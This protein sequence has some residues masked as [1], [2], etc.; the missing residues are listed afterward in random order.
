[1]TSAYGQ[2]RCRNR[3][4]PFK[5]AGEILQM[6][7]NSDNVFE[8]WGTAQ[9]KFMKLA[10]HVI[11]TGSEFEYPGC[12]MENVL[13][14]NYSPEDGNIVIVG[15]R[16]GFCSF[17][18]DDMGYRESCVFRIPGEYFFSPKK[19]QKILVGYA[20]HLQKQDKLRQQEQERREYEEYMRLKAKYE[21]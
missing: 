9:Q 18:D 5:Q 6:T 1:M 12:L 2:A 13:G 7:S 14:L 10:E 8:N 4:S 11:Q 16:T 17:D 19:W 3:S 21:A 15:D 20:E